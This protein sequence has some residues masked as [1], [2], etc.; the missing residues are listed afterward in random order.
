MTNT[1]TYNHTNS[2]TRTGYNETE[3]Q[4][5]CRLSKRR[6]KRN[7]RKNLALIILTC[8]LLIGLIIG[9]FVG[10]NATTYLQAA[11]IND[12]GRNM[13]FTTYT[14]KPG[15]TVWDIAKDL[16]VLN[17]EYNDIRQY[18]AE[19]EDINKLAGEDIKAGQQIIIPYYVNEDGLIDSNEIYSKYGIGK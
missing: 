16:I 19:I 11:K 1:T 9:F 7:L 8:S 13:M 14:V 15:D 6:I 12:Y 3:W 17:P 18:V 10:M 5:L 2:R 4:K